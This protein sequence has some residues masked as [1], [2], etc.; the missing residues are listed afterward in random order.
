MMHQDARDF[1]RSHRRMN[2]FRNG[3]YAGWN[4]RIADEHLHRS[5]IVLW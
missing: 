3:R 5:G 2:R 1:T 4:P